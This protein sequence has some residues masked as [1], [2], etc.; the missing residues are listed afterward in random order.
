MEF[1]ILGPLEVRSDG[2]VLDLGGPQRRA[3]LAALLLQPNRVVA[4]DRLVDLLWD[5]DPPETARKVLQ[6]HVSQLR[7]AIGRERLQT[8]APGYLIALGEDELDLARFERLRAAGRFDEALAL[9]RGP[10]LADLASQ[11]FIAAEVAR[12]EEMR[13]ACVEERVERALEDGGHAA[14]AGEL[15]ALV[16][17]HPHRER[18]R[19]QL[20]LALYRSG[21]QAEALQA[22]RAARRAL[23]DELGIEPG[24]ELQALHRAV[25][26]Q[27]PALDLPSEA[28]AG[29][30]RGAFVGR[31]R[32]L[33]ELERGLDDAF[34]GHG[35]L[36][37]VAGEP[38]AGKSRLADELGRQAAERGARVLVGRCWEAGGA[39]PY[40]PWVQALGRLPEPPELDTE[41]ARFWLFQ[42]TSAFLRASAEGEPL[43][44]V[45]DDLHAADEP[46]LLLLRF[47]AR[48]L[49]DCRL[50][51]I[52]AYR[53]VD[54]AMRDPLHATLAELVREPHT[55][56][57]HLAGLGERAVGR[58]L[59]LSTGAR[60]TSSLVEEVHAETDGNPLFVVEL[61]RLLDAEGLLGEPRAEVPIPPG[62]RAVI[63]RRVGRLS[64]PCRALLYSASVLGRE[65]G[66]DALAEMCT[67]AR[68]E[69]LDTLDE[70][71]AERIVVDAPAAP[72]Q[73]RFGHALIRDTLYDDLTSARRLRLHL[74]A[75]EALEAVYEADPEPHL[76]E[77][78]HHFRAAAPV[79]ATDRAVAY[80]RR[81]GDRAIVTLAFEEAERQY[82]AALILVD[83]AAERCELL[84]GLGEARARAGDTP[85]SKRAFREAAD[86]A[87]RTGLSEALA[88]AALGYG[89][90]M[91]WD[92]AR[93]DDAV[94]QLLER[95]LTTIGTDDSPLRVRLLARIAGGPLR[96]STASAQRRE[97][98]GAE[99][100]ACARRVGDPATLAYALQGYILAHHS[101]DHTRRQLELADELVAVATEAG[102][103]ERIVEGGEERLDALVELGDVEGAKAELAAM[104]KVAAE[105]RQPS[106]AWFV[107]VY[108][109]LFA[110]LEGRLDEA[111]NLVVRARPIGERALTWSAEVSYRLQLYLL[112]REQGRLTEVEGLM[113]DSVATYSTYPIFRC[114]HAQ[115]LA[116]LGRTGEARAALEALVGDDGVSLPFDEEWLVSMGLLSETAAA[117]KDAGRAAVLYQL[118][119]P[120]GDRIAICYPEI[121]TGPVAR[122]LGI[123]AATLGRTRDAE[124]H[125]AEAVALAERIGA[126]PWV[127]RTRLAAS[128]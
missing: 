9:W 13:V 44:L 2:R 81:A 5:D 3:L 101:P 15:E 18:L 8:R 87:E 116:E 127:D 103:K 64:E 65:F 17:E 91:I 75:G 100:L 98:L 78:A 23:V 48:E 96:D 121:S 19:G 39:P 74:S 32:E 108:E 125:F 114:V 6:L 60:P 24:R 97:A 89:A 59:E 124:R 128:G 4:R 104:T 22:Y 42:A 33:G 99:A 31:D 82:E 37:L 69:L 58:Y 54:P 61:V 20:M 29:G 27:D 72:G 35:R 49:A 34:G 7:K 120:Y 45:L 55:A 115:V 62:I 11:R 12:L 84:L 53:D 66:L 88:R 90:R 118:L 76:A 93:D 77:L 46:S 92:V 79:G 28:A 122:Y 41:G 86:L 68:D 1:R 109:A 94:L 111:E 47:V 102:D 95:A 113:R 70:A 21:R 26:E 63:A 73:L 30:P 106:H 117:V 112:R 40:W 57:M 80:S 14:L 51:L 85:A 16:A 52:A 10:A 123:L 71:M 119:A 50:L 105:L 38:G 25:L 36:F 67:L 110:L 83:D 126:R 107:A 56:Q 43:V